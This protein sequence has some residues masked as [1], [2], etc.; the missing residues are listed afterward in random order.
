MFTGWLPYM[1]V[2]NEQ[3]VNMGYWDDIIMCV[4][5]LFMINYNLKQKLVAQGVVFGTLYLWNLSNIYNIYFLLG[6]FSFFKVKSYVTLY[7]ESRKS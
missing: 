7:L 4:F 2:T 1:V 6:F 5:V 3:R